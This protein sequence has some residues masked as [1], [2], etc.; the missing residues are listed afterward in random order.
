M[1]RIG[2]YLVVHVLAFYTLVSFFF[3]NG[4]VG[5]L[6]QEKAKLSRMQTEIMEKQLILLNEKSQLLSSQSPKNVDE[7]LLKH[8]YK[9]KNTVIFRFVDSKTSL[10]P[11]RE[12]HLLHRVY[13]VFFVLTGG[14]L[15]GE[16]FLY[17]LRKGEPLL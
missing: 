10:K 4:G 9:P 2:I 1:K 8:G 17:A 15:L 14:L 5:N 12:I 3:G 7:Y 6:L 13:L 16:L 11:S